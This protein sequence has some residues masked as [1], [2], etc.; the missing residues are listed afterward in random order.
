ML[1]HYA[2]CDAIERGDFRWAREHIQHWL[3]DTKGAD[4]SPLQ[5]SFLSKFAWHTRDWQMRDLAIAHTADWTL[6]PNDSIDMREGVGLTYFHIGMA[7]LPD[8]TRAFEWLNRALEAIPDLLPAMV[9]RDFILRDLDRNATM[10]ALGE[11]LPH[12]AWRYELAA[13]ELGLPS[14]G[15]SPPRPDGLRIGIA[16]RGKADARTPALMRWYRWAIGER[17]LSICTWDDTDPTIVAELRAVCDEV[18]LIPDPE[19]P[20]FQNRARQIGLAQAALAAN[21]D[22]CDLILMTRTDI[23]LFRPQLLDALEILWQQYP[24]ADSRLRGRLIVPDV[25]TRRYMTDHPSD[26]IMFGHIEDMQRYWAPSPF[27]KEQHKVFLEQYL[28]RNFRMELG[29]HSDRHNLPPSEYMG[30]LRD[31]FVVRDFGWYQGWWL[32]RRKELQATR[33]FSDYARLVSQSFWD[34]LY[35]ANRD[36]LPSHHW[37]P[38]MRGALLDA[39]FPRGQA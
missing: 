6:K 26:M 37:A 7:F 8:R 16:I 5:L 11:E 29:I 30:Y 25:Y 32:S 31:Y 15:A 10:H 2:L 1:N 34:S 19:D 33:V 22:R 39:T 12:M 21:A 18:I 9:E 20:G 23:V 14:R 17:P 13:S 36:N 35:Y 3:D 28:S 24:I 38:R 27:G 4:F